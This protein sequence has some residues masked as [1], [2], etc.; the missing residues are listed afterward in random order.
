MTFD[1][2]GPTLSKWAVLPNPTSL[3]IQADI[4]KIQPVM[5]KQAHTSHMLMIVVHQDIYTWFSGPFE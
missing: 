1:D 3:V 4:G 5:K 2:H